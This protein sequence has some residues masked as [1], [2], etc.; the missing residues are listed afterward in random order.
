MNFSQFSLTFEDFQSLSVIHFN[1]D[2]VNW[3]QI[4]CK[5]LHIRVG[6]ACEIAVNFSNSVHEF[7][8]NLSTFLKTPTMKYRIFFCEL[9]LSLAVSQKNGIKP[10]CS[11]LQLNG[12]SSCL[13]CM[14][15]RYLASK[16]CIPEWCEPV[17]ITTWNLYLIFWSALATFTNHCSLK[18]P[19]WQSQLCQP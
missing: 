2:V 7:S 1:A 4:C 14:I 10:Q 13:F 9:A 16:F 12:F 5:M 8:I 6:K 3:W 18:M 15:T 17:V 19:T 11:S